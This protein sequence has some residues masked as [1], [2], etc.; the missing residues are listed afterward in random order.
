MAIIGILASHI[1][2]IYGHSIAKEKTLR[3]S[4]IVIHVIVL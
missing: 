1:M 4:S 3:S 2:A